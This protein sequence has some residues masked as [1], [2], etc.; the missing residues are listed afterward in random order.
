MPEVLA[1]LSNYEIERNKPIPNLTHGGLQANII[2][3][4]YIILSITPFIELPV[5]CLWIQLPKVLHR[6]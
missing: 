2:G 5:K 3:Q 6:M 4:L 1:S